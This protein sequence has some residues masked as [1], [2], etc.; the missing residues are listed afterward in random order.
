MTAGFAFVLSTDQRITFFVGRGFSRDI[1][2][3]VITG[4][5]PLKH[6]ATYDRQAPPYQF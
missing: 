6:V 2:V 5:Q 3:P 1:H 4:L